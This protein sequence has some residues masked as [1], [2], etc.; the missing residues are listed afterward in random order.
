MCVSEE[1]TTKTS[2]IQVI[3]DFNSMLLHVM[4]HAKSLDYIGR[5]ETLK[6]VLIKTFDFS[7]MIKY[8]VGQPWKT[9]QTEPKQKLIEAFTDFTIATY[10][11]RFNGYSGEK[12]KTKNQQDGPRG[13]KLIKTELVKKDGSVIKLNYL[14]RKNER[15]WQIIDIFLKGSISELATKRSE[16]NATVK[17][18]GLNS[19]I[20][21]IKE[22]AVAIKTQNVKSK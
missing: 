12:I 15:G 10:A 5:Y 20:G 19:L 11:D 21:R 14:L 4:K 7:F 13:T 9:L 3:K 1:T 2:A 6:P 16:Y 17:K 18:Y 8:A 22:R